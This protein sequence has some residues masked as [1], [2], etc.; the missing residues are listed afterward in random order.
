[1]YIHCGGQELNNG[2]SPSNQMQADAVEYVLHAVNRQYSRPPSVLVLTPYRGQHTLLT[3]QLAGY[4][5]GQVKVS[6]ID[7]AQGQEADL[8]IISFVRANATGSVGFTDDA[9]RLNV[10]ITRAKA[11]VIIVGHLATSLAASTSGFGSLLYEPRKQG[12]IYEY[13]HGNAN[14]PMVM[15][16]KEDFKKY[17]EEFPA[18]TAEEQRRRKREG[19]DTASHG[20]TYDVKRAPEDDI[21]HAVEKTKRYLIALTRS[22][23]FMLAMSHVCSLE[24]KIEYNNDTPPNSVVDWDRKTW[25][26]QNFFST[27]G[28]S[29]DVGNFILGTM[30]LSIRLALGMEPPINLDRRSDIDTTGS[31]RPA[32]W[33]RD[34]C[35]MH[36]IVSGSATAGM[37][38]KQG[39][40]QAISNMSNLNIQPAECLR[41]VFETLIH[42]EEGH[43]VSLDTKISD[44]ACE[45]MGDVL[46][47]AGGL[48]DPYMPAAKPFMMSMHEPHGIDFTN[49]ADACRN[50]QGLAQGTKELAGMLPTPKAEDGSPGDNRARMWAILKELCPDGLALEPRW[51]KG[52]WVC[53][54]IT[55]LG[56]SRLFNEDGEAPALRDVTKRLY[57]A[58]EFV[59]F[60]RARKIRVSTGARLKPRRA[61]TRDEQRTVAEQ[62][63]PANSGHHPRHSL[64]RH[65]EQRNVQM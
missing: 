11:G 1:M 59:E 65:P 50:L 49:D 63:H 27:P 8:V 15:M 53:N 16:T 41:V 18:D 42:D 51:C 43:Q 38:R 4:N 45:R 35:T 57:C 2:N 64:E 22:T 33:D 17:R 13:Q 26:S 23:S 61:W 60:G 62:H 47:A 5:K 39:Y 36:P 52:C 24:Q 28:V 54:E 56:G 32:R 3:R 14:P 31:H 12:A 25:S 21:K 58:K 55:R 40:C 46:E 29:V 48:I 7:A 20:D 44:A 9:K 37:A 10:A 6:T 19:K 30:F 34:P